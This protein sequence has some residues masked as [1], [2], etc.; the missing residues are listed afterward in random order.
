VQ[1][2]LSGKAYYECN[3]AWVVTTGHYTPNAKELAKKHAKKIKST[4]KELAASSND[5]PE[6]TQEV[7]RKKAILEAAMARAKAQLDSN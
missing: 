1:E 5:T 7:A 4:L 2:V 3:E 6:K